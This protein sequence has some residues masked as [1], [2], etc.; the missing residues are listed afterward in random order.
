VDNITPTIEFIITEPTNKDSIQYSNTIWTGIKATDPENGEPYDGAINR[1]YYNVTGPNGYQISTT[2]TTSC[3]FDT[4]SLTKDGTYNITTWAKDST[5]NI[6]DIN[7]TNVTVDLKPKY[8]A[9]SFNL[10]QRF[11]TTPQNITITAQFQ[12]D[13]AGSITNCTT[14][15][16]NSTATTSTNAG[17]LNATNISDTLN[18]TGNITLPTTDEMYEAWI[19]ITDSEGDT[20][21]TASQTLYICNNRTSKGTGTNGEQWN[22]IYRDMDINAKP[23]ICLRRTAKRNTYIA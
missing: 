17:Y 10:T 5:G 4:T 16:K 14:Y 13:D 12:T 8:V 19:N 2:S 1:C 22:C 23:D 7:I 3:R 15:Y 9:N 11:H 6:G 20:T 21:K 18:C